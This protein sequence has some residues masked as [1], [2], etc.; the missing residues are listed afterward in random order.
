[1][2]SGSLL[3]TD[4]KD[5]TA[6]LPWTA[7]LSVV[8]LGSFCARLTW[9]ELNEM[10]LFQA[11]ETLPRIAYISLPSKWIFLVFPIHRRSELVCDGIRVGIGDIIV[12]HPGERVHQRTDAACLWGAIAL[13]PATLRKYGKIVAGREV[14]ASASG[15]VFRP[16]SQDWRRLRHLHAEAI[17]I[18]ET[19][20]SH[21]GHHEVAKA[22]E[23]DAICSLITCLMTA[24]W[25]HRSEEDSE[26]A[27]ILARFEEA[28]TAK[29]EHS[30]RLPEIC[31]AIGVSAQTLRNCCLAHLD[32]GPGEYLRLRRL[33]RAGVGRPDA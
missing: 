1:M 15:Q 10:R 18:A 24:E 26:R 7:Q 31:K 27:R 12:H 8:R 21:L 5:Y 2:G 19:Q 22:I 6:S 23:Q 33:N 3:F 30:L 4:A 32:I 11:R 28:L 13:T 25:R 16:V 29:P 17:R 14:M 9:I 20:L